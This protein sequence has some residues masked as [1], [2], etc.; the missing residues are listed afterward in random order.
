MQVSDELGYT[1]STRFYGPEQVDNLPANELAFA[2]RLASTEC[3]KLEAV[4]DRV[5]FEGAYVL[6]REP[7]APA[8]P[9]V[10][11]VR[12]DSDADARIV[13]RFV[14]NQNQ[15]PFLIVESPLQV[16][17]YPGFEFDRDAD[18]PLVSV[19][20]IAADALE[21]LSAFHANSI[22][23][24]ELWSKWSDAVDPSKRVDEALLRDLEALDKRL[25][26]EGVD[27]TTSHGLIGKFVYLR[28]LRDRAI[29]SDVK[30]AAW[31]IDAAQVFSRNATLK[32]FRSVDQELQE[33]LNGSVFSFG[34]AELRDITQAQLRLVAGVFCGD[35]PVGE[36]AVQVSLFDAYN[37]SH[38]PI[39]TLSCV[40]EQFLHDAKEKNGDSRGKTLGAYYTPLP[41]ADYVLSELERRRPLTP[42]MIVLDPACGSGAFL[43]QCYRRLI[44]SER[45]REG[46]ELKKS[47]LRELLTRHIFGIDRDDDACRVAELSLI[48][49]LLD[50]V[51]PPDLENTKFK[52][53]CLRDKNVFQ[54]D[55]FDESGPVYELLS[56][57]R[58]DWIA[59][60]PPWA[61]VKGTPAADHEHYVVHQWMLAHKK[62]HPTSGNQIVEAF[63]WKAGEHLAPNG[64]CGL[65]VVAM[66]WF[67]KE[68]TNFRE[69]F[70]AER[71]VWCLANFANMGFVLFARR[72]NVGASVVFFEAGPASDTDTIL[73]FSPF[74][75]EQVANRPIKQKST[76]STWNIV[77]GSTDIREVNALAAKRGDSL[78]WK[79]AMWGSSRDRKLL[80]RL[81]VRFEDDK[82]DSLLRYGIKKPHQG[83]EL[84]S[85]SDREKEEVKY[86]PELIGKA[87]LKFG[88]LRNAGRL[89]EFPDSAI[90]PITRDECYVRVRGGL[91]GLDVSYPPHIVV[92]ASRRFAIYSN[93]FLAIPA[94]QIGIRGDS[95]SSKILRALSLYLS[96]DFC[97]YHQFFV[98]PQWGVDM[99]RADL[100]ALVDMP[101]PLGRL[102]SPDLNDWA[103]LQRQLASNSKELFRLNE[104]GADRQRI[105]QNL[106]DDLN[107]RV[108]NLLG[109]KTTERW[110]IED[111]VGTQLELTKGKVTQE[112][113]RAPSPT[114]RQEYLIALRKCLDSYLSED[115]NL[116]HKIEVLADQNAAILSISLVRSKS[117]IAPAILD[118]DDP[119]SRNLERVRKSILAKHSQWLYFDR[120]LKIYQRG[121]LYHFKPLQRLHWTRRQAVLDADDIIA[122]TLV[123]GA[124]S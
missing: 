103:E 57:Q 107:E 94:R 20:K 33:W 117:V 45:R 109:L 14:W 100:S 55:F 36:D 50:Y 99:N 35:S 23:N 43:V 1:R 24:G 59:G 5:R 13:H 49:T 7:G 47:E 39:E 73:T 8:V 27:R 58:F 41:L 61:E 53:P 120:G 12:C 75:A 114:E 101:T 62:T 69:R 112:V 104:S 118:A 106:L 111:F 123:E 70:F 44:E 66:T 46:R 51:E 32:A 31:E 30:L 113:T 105:P 90:E 54:G 68:A 6:Q 82:F 2:L 26:K 98:S 56:A 48:M 10:Y 40:Y 18:H 93:E 89:F 3:P 42:G 110:L 37:F 76:V 97:I 74:V 81:N 17:V 15:T 122:E 102:S 79:L 25:Q 29:L 64:A 9:I 11:L 85:S 108:F 88:K 119:T 16:R 21:I 71:R 95:K 124:A 77:V 60:N 92:D 72:S 83:F 67:K 96:S 34:E 87:K 38:I 121:I 84:R 91:A 22:D 80:E 65:V 52:L 19:T 4:S 86:H 78:T 63:L 116:R 115:R 28:Y